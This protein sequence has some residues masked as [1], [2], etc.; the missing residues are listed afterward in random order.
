[1]RAAGDLD[2]LKL[3]DQLLGEGVQFTPTSGD[4]LPLRHPGPS[5][6]LVACRPADGS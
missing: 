4:P 1:M 3:L 2:L 5:R 6:D